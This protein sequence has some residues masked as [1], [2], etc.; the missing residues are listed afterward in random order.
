MHEIV[1]IIL[2]CMWAWSSSNTEF[3]LFFYFLYK[4]L[5]QMIVE[6]NL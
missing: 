2:N 1:S 5:Y 3:V 6:T 4:P